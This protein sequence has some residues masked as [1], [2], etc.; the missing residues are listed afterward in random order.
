MFE[1]I[2]ETFS[3]IP[4]S[5]VFIQNHFKAVVFSTIVVA[6]LLPSGDA[7]TSEANL[8]RL[9]VTGP[10]MDAS[11]FMEDIKHIEES[12]NI[13]GVLLYVD[14]PGGAVAPSVEMSMAVKRLATKLPVVTYVGGT[15]ASG[16]LY[17]SVYSPLIIANPGSMIG[18]IGV[19]FEGANIEG[20]M[21][22][23]GVK[24]QVVKMGTYKQ[25]G[26]PL[27]EWTK[28]ERGELEHL[29]GQTYAMFVADVAKGRKL[30]PA[31]LNDF[32]DAHV[33]TANE[34]KQKGLVDRLGS[35]YDAQ[36]ELARRAKVEKVVWEE[37]SDFDKFMSK[38]AQETM[39]QIFTHVSGL[40][41]Y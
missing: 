5:L 3:L 7:P 38:M 34:A 18:S 1:K 20:L 11:K 30:D 22:K 19:V 13:K 41:A 33:F 28:E 21:E 27:R 26:T 36:D 16:S 31:K 8:A 32:A 23:L 24:S 14:S 35:F 40:K 17:A 39:T 37:K 6:L 29:L 10:I 2:K 15:M 4:R 9:E 25:A 12:P